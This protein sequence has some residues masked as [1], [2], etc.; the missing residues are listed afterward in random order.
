MEVIVVLLD[1]DYKHTLPVM[2]GGT[3]A[4]EIN[5]FLKASALLMDVNK[6][7]MT[8]DMRVQLHNDT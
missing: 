7:C 2:N 5:A 8:T 6:F 4:F 1:D 3:L